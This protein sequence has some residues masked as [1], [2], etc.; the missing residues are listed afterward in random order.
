MPLVQ[1]RQY[2]YVYGQNSY[3]KT[4]RGEKSFSELS[5]PNLNAHKYFI[6]KNKSENVGKSFEHVFDIDENDPYRCDQREETHHRHILPQ[7]KNND[8]ARRKLYLGH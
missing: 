1:N 2:V 6:A 7:P 4:E 3:H 8:I 5:D